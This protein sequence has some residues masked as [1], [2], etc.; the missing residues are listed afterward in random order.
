[1]ALIP[2]AALSIVFFLIAA[3]RVGG[4][5]FHIWQA[6]LFGALIVLFTG[7]ISPSD[8]FKAVN[9]DV[10]LFLS[11]MFVVGSA[12]ELSGY[13]SHLSYKSFKKAGSVD[14]LVLLILFGL[15]LASAFLMNDTCAIIGTPVVLA[16]AGKYGIPPKLLL[17]TLAFAI[18]LGS[19]PS[20]IGN[21]QNLLVAVN[22][23]LES[24]F[25]AFLWFL[26][27][28]TLVNLFIAYLLLKFFYREHFRRIPLNLSDE[29][30][31][32]AGLARLAR[33]SMILVVLLV[34]VKVSAVFLDR[35]LDYG[36]TYIAL[37]AALPLLV[38]SPR[39]REILGKVDWST[40]VFFASM[41]VLMQ[42]VW[43]SGFF[44]EVIEDAAMDITTVPAIFMISVGLS[45]LI[46]N[47]PLVALYMPMLLHAGVS[48]KELMA[49]A[50]GST[51]A[52]NLFILGAASNVIIIQNA[53]KK[54]ETLTFMEFAKIGIPLTLVNILVYWLF[55]SIL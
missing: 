21:P 35:N 18:T 33:I 9:M 4:V 39:R 31:S 8:A 40:L 5:R 17:L 27:L 50:A 36:L 41:F 45:Q 55:L 12:L 32:D 2:V 42:S 19:V 52:G 25:T 51:I 29:P 16:L 23:G 15:G 47:V 53:E 44:Q 34:L 38:F 24:P 1:M 28:P 48:T 37:A 7:Q 14:A 3:R 6:M 43:D 20:P 49:L 10:I 13:L 46:S 26:F 54:G 11:G 30:V 22:G